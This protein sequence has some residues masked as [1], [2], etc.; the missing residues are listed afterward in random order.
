MTKKTAKVHKM[1]HRNKDGFRQ[2]KKMS[3]IERVE[4]AVKRL[5]SLPQF[6]LQK[7][8]DLAKVVQDLR[9]TYE[10]IGRILQEKNIISQ[11]EVTDMGNKLLEE[12]RVENEKRMKLMKEQ[13]D[14]KTAEAREKLD[15][16][17]PGEVVET[18]SEDE[19]KK[20]LH[21]P[22]D[23][24]LRDDVAKDLMTPREDL[25]EDQ[26]QAVDVSINEKDIDNAK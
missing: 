1:P 3:R 5:S 24:S 8:Q 7:F 14:T 12:Q 26:I 19:A 23:D 13:A 4:Q 9:F 20:E 25:Q 2:T 16:K 18:L 21:G 6:L 17:I 11:Q 22:S 10:V 15:G